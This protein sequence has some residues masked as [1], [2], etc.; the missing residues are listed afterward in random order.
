MKRDMSS[1]EAETLP[2]GHACTTSK[3]TRGSVPFL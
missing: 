3:G 1:A 2:A